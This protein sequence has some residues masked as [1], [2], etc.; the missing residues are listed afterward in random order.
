MFSGL[1]ISA[2]NSGL[3]DRVQA[4][5]RSLCCMLGKT[6]SQLT[7]NSASL[8]LEYKWV[9]QIVG[10]ACWVVTPDRLVSHPGDPWKVG[11]QLSFMLQSAENSEPAGLKRLYLL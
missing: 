9:P 11:L 2:L 7:V 6:L 4:L 3:S 8:R 5:T 10:K 1:M